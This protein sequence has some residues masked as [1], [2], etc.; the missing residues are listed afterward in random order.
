MNWSGWKDSM[1]RCRHDSYRDRQSID[2]PRVS[3]AWFSRT[4]LV[5]RIGMS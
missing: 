5:N 3:R 2:F 1:L 4:T